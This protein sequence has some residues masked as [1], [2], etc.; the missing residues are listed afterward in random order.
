MPPELPSDAKDLIRRMLEVN[1]EKRI[2]V[3]CSLFLHTREALSNL[4]RPAQMEQIQ[5]HPWMTR[6][7]PRSINGAPP[8]VPPSLDQIDHPVASRRDI[9]PDILSNLRTLWNGASEHEITE[10]LLSDE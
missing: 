1:P 8:Y 7:P 10:A 5:V 2:T 9:D 3:S 4:H 6:N